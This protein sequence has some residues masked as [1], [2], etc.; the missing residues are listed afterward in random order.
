MTADLFDRARKA[1]R[2]YKTALA[3]NDLAQMRA[4]YAA[5]K[6]VKVE[7]EQA[8]KALR[9]NSPNG[10]VTCLGCG[11]VFKPKGIAQ[12]CSVSCYWSIPEHRAQQSARL[13]EVMREQWR[14]YETRARQREA[15]REHFGA[16]LAEAYK[17]A[18]RKQ[19]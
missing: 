13:S 7:L 3:A 10:L 4:Y 11:K 8:M 12:Y 5:I 18:K 2:E 19:D 14:T 9:A 16:A 17:A 15:M 6:E 1:L